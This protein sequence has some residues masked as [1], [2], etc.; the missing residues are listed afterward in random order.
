M[1]N[2]VIRKEPDQ[3][4]THAEKPLE[5]PWRNI[6]KRNAGTAQSARWRWLWNW[7]NY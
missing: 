5:F 4:R 6:W 7:I 2:K 3:W 1:K